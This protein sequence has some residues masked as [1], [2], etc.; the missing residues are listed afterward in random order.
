MSQHSLPNDEHAMSAEARILGLRSKEAG[1]STATKGGGVCGQLSWNT[2]LLTQTVT[3]ILPSES[4]LR[5]AA[6]ALPFW[7][8]TQCV[9]VGKL[10]DVRSRR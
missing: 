6:S 7:L 4:M 2:G 3:V 10:R 8:T 9:V 5:V 1:R